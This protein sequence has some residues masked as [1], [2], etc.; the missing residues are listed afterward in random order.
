LSAS[1]ATSFIKVIFVARKL[2]AA[3]FISSAVSQSVM[4]ISAPFSLKI[5]YILDSFSMTSC[6]SQVLKPKTTLSGL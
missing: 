1:L 4:K 6:F 2:F 5:S 3:Y